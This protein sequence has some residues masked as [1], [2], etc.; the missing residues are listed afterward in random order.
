MKKANKIYRIYEEKKNHPQAHS[1]F[2]SS[3][4]WIDFAI[5]MSTKQQHT[6]TQVGKT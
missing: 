3:F 5:C 6:H 1:I 2:F 4:Y